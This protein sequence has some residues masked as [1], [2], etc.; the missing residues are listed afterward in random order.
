MQV[1]FVTHYADLYGA[2]LSMLNMI[3]ELKNNYNVIPIVLVNEKGKLTDELEKNNIQYIVK[4]YYICAINNK[5]KSIWFK[6][7]RKKLVRLITYQHIIYSI[8]RANQHI[9]LVHTNS[10]MTD[11]GYFISKNMKCPH[12]WH[13]REYGLEDYGLLQIDRQQKIRKRYEKSKYIIA[14]SKSIEK[15][16][17][18]ISDKVYVKTIYN[19]VN[20]PPEYSKNYNKK[21]NFCLVGLICRNKNQIEAVMAAKILLE[22]GVKNFCVNIVGNDIE[23]EKQRII[24]F[25]K[26]YHLENYINLVGYKKDINNYLVN[27]DVGI[28]TSKKEAFGRVTIEYMSNYMPVIGTDTGGTKEL[29]KNGENGFLYERNNCASLAHLMKIIIDNPQLLLE[30]GNKARKFSLEFSVERNAKAVYEIY[31]SI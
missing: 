28:L 4:K 19:G 29:I 24:D 31:K 5:E 3:L 20:I 16:I 13:I 14:I 11:I 26:V 9:D 22:S 6:K 25:I 30:M 1:L 21:I 10:S 15:M 18:K 12:V 2:N 17:R 7:V 8:K 23:G 27:M